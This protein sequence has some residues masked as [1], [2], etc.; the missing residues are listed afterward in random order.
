MNPKTSEIILRDAQ[1]NELEDVSQLLVV[2][3]KEYE[4]FMPADRWDWYRN[5]MMDVSART[6]DSELIV[7]EIN[8]R[9]VGT[10]T[11]YSEGSINVWPAGWAGIRLLAVH[12]D[13]RGKGIGHAL[14]DECITRCRK[15]GTKTIGLHTTELMKVAR[16]M[17]ERMGFK[18]V[19]EF[20]FH[21]QPDKVVFAYRLDI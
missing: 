3:Y 19:P 1:P 4:E 8:K 9:I 21:P 2:A 11:L 6:S 12:P 14:M 10:V 20:D 13:Y 18:R 7:A 16:S 17:Y 15:H 5:D